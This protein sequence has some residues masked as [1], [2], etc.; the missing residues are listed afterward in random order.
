VD[1]FWALPENQIDTRCPVMKKAAM[2]MKLAIK[3]PLTSVFLK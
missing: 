3:T 2:M 1:Y